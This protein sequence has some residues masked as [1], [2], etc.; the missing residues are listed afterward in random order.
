MASRKEQKEQARAAR[1]AKQEAAAA[2]T[3][4]KRRLQIFGGVT[5]VAVIVIVV[6]IIVSSGGSK[7]TS[8]LKP[9]S[10]QATAVYRTVNAELKDIPESG[11][12]LGFPSAKV[13]LNYWGDLQCPICMEF[14]TGEDGGGLPEF[15]QK[16]VRT[17]H[18][19][20]HY[21]SLCTATCSISNPT[22]GNSVFNEQQSAAYAAGK[23]N[24]AWYYIELFYRQQGAEDSGYATRSFID[25]IAEQIP[26]LNLKTWET[27]V[28]SKAVVAQVNADQTAGEQK[29]GFDATP[30]FTITG[31][32][33]T[34]TL[35]S[36]VLTYADLTQAVKAVS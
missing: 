14:S 22:G 2:Q 30:S 36:G 13:T 18:A 15:V 34:Q 27:G 7:S 1:L 24:L 20:V 32:K 10:A 21:E 11:T 9:H 35:G 25:G 23:Q 16:Q 6:A 28:G 17:G 26:K 4:R 5:A 29:Y 8:G 19:K 31:P 33:G 12:T 3:Q